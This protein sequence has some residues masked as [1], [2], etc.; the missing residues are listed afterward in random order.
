MNATSSAPSRAETWA[1]AAAKALAELAE[2]TLCMGVAERAEVLSKVPE[3][4]RGALIQVV[5]DPSMRLGVFGSKAACEKLARALLAVEEGD[6]LSDDEIADAIREIIN[7][8]AGLAKRLVD[9]NVSG[10][11]GLPSFGSANDTSPPEPHA[12][13]VV[14]TFNVSSDEGDVAIVS[15]GKEC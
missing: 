10:N 13:V 5:W 2:T 9:E 7:M 1:D 6:P 14:K 4:M 8:V 11:L 12:L 3:H 15:M